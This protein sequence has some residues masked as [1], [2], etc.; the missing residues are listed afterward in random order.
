MAATGFPIGFELPRLQGFNFVG[1]WRVIPEFAALLIGLV[2]YTAAF[3]AETVRGGILAVDRAANRK[4]RRRSACRAGR[5][6]GLWSFRR[7]CG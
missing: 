4:R 2:V 1:G 7:R 6:C 5:R 3:I